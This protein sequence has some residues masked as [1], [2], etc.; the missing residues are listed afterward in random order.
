MRYINIIECLIVVVSALTLRPSYFG[1]IG[2]ELTIW[3]MLLIISI[4]F[5][6]KLGMKNK[7]MYILFLI[8][9]A[10]SLAYCIL[11]A[12]DSFEIALKTFLINALFLTTIFILVENTDVFGNVYKIVMSIVIF[13]AIITLS[14]LKIDDIENSLSNYE[15]M[16]IVIKDRE[17]SDI[18]YFP[19]T[20]IISIFYTPLFQMPRFTFMAI[21]PGVAIAYIATWYET[22]KSYKFKIIKILIY[23]CCSV[24]TLSTAAIPLCIS[25]IL[26]NNTKSDRKFS[27]IRLIK[28]SI[29]PILMLL[30]LYNIPYIG[31]LDKIDTHGTSFEDREI[32]YRGTFI[33]ALIVILVCIHIS[34]LLRLNILK[35]KYVFYFL[36]IVV[37]IINVLSFSPMYFLII[38]IM[39]DIGDK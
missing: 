24:M 22:I 23:I 5:S 7:K 35:K 3:L 11:I 38:Y 13:S 28:L 18:I 15:L 19:F 37:C 33:P 9:M 25:H 39:S 2:T 1:Y 10:F 34:L 30:L 8:N 26:V 31:V 29:V 21:E 16:Q 6:F 14:L 27:V 12:N 32:F 20:T 36:I 17:G 4:S